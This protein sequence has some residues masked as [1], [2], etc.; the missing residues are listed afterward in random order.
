MK[1]RLALLLALSLSFASFPVT[2]VGA[3]EADTPAAAT[4]T[5]EQA[6]ETQPE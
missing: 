3:A 4:Q 1:R 6:E 5:V 2:G